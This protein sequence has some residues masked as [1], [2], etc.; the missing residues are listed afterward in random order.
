MTYSG[1]SE[2]LLEFKTFKHQEKS[3]NKLLRLTTNLDPNYRDLEIGQDNLLSTKMQ[4]CVKKFTQMWMKKIISNAEYLLFIN[5]A[6]NRS[7]NDASQ[8][9]IFPWVLTNYKN[10]KFPDFE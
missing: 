4:A 3:L 2:Y 7:F 6:S 8:Y 5:F 9:P 1:N 10:E